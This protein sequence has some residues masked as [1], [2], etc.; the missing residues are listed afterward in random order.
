M[1]HHRIHPYGLAMFFCLL[2]TFAAG[3]LNIEKLQQTADSL[4]IPQA[5]KSIRICDSMLDG[6][7]G[8]SVNRGIFYRIRGK[9]YY[10]Q[11]DYEE[12]GR[13]YAEAIKLLDANTSGTELG[14][15]LIEQA[16]LYRKLKMFPQAIAEYNKAKILFE[17]LGEKNHLASVLNEWGVVYEL[18]QDYPRA[19][20]FYKQS[21]AIKESLNDLVGIAYSNSFLSTVYLLTENYALAEIYAEKSLQL[22]KQLKDPYNIA[23]QSTDMALIYEKKKDYKYAIHLLESSD[24]VAIAMGNPDL[25]S[26][27]KMRLATIYATLGDFSNAFRYQQQY[28]ALK[29]SLFTAS[30]QKAIAELN[31]QYQ[32]AEKDKRILEQENNLARQRWILSLTITLLL[33]SGL[34]VLFIFKNRKLREEQIINKARYQDEMLRM[35]AQ[36]NLQRDRLR[37]S[38]DLHDNIGAY[39]T[40]INAGINRIDHASSDMDTLRQITQESIVELRRTVWLINKPCV[41]LEE[42]VIKL[43]EYHLK[44]KNISIN[45][46]MENPNINMN[47]LQ[48]TALFRIIQEG[49]NNA[50]KYASAGLIRIFILQHDQELSVQIDDDGIGFDPG[51]VQNGFGLENMK[52]RTQELHGHYA[53]ESSTGSGTRISIHI[54]ITNT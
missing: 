17:N 36:N 22:F 29:D 43:R 14:I 21:L 45:V 11:G 26:A 23:L 30:S 33:A 44:I 38:R 9:A 42:W 34:I 16:K 48:A 12:A 25:S 47:A 7:Q 39:L 15:T 1:N 3:Q 4:A 27:N 10:F 46:D 20:S 13:N 49:V 8:S 18:M 35:E 40:F 5:S 28:A 24:S 19:V 51:N 52:Q 37:I 41:S 53:I 32:T 6:A 54:P 31:I 50:V 2:S